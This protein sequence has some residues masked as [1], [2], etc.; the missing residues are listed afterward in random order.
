MRFLQASIPALPI[1]AAASGFAQTAVLWTSAPPAPG[2]TMREETRISLEK[3]SFSLEVNHQPLQGTANAMAHD[4]VERTFVSSSEQKISVLDSARNFRFGFGGGNSPPKDTAGHLLGKK[5]TGTKTG[6]H[7]VFTLAGERKPDAAEASALKQF[8]IYSEA[9][10]ALGLLYG[11]AP[12]KVGETWKPDIGAVKRANPEFDADL[13]CKL[14][15]LRPREGDTIAQISVT[16]RFRAG[17]RNGGGIQVAINGV[18]HRSLRDMVDLDA[19]VN[20]N[21]RY[22]GQFG[23]GG[24]NAEITA[25]VTL[26]RTVTI[27]K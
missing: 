27:K 19:E 8:T 10:E 2:A 4:V 13:E 9:V 25:P 22:T 21:F 16:G 3:G 26:K 5:L 14:D 23:K 18:I 17:I 24:G 15:E 11:T 6:G 1:L 7:W 20:G 12:R